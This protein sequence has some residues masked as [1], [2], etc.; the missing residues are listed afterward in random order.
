MAFEDEA[1]H[2]VGFS[3]T[4]QLL[5]VEPTFIRMNPKYYNYSL[6]LE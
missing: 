3:Q 1:K 6:L 5:G 2:K 4:S